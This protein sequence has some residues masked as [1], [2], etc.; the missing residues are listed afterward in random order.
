[1]PSI[2]HDSAQD[3]ES[4]SLMLDTLARFH[5]LPASIEIHEHYIPADAKPTKQSTAGKRRIE[6]QNILSTG[7]RLY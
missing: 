4:A 6:F 1:M 2:R 5:R 7:L 3:D